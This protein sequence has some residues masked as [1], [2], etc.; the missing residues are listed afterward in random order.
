M[1]LVE[2]ERPRLLGLAYRLVGGRTD[3]ED[4]VQDAWLRWSTAD[5]EAILNPPAWLTTVTTRLALDRIREVERRRETYVGPW[6]PDPIST[7]R[8]PEEHSELAESLTLGFLVVLD[9]LSPVERA[10]LLLADVFAEPFSIIAT[11]VGKSEVACRQIATRARRK[12]RAGAAGR[13]GSEAGTSGTTPATAQLLSELMTAIMTGDEALVIKLVDPDIVLITDGG[14]E[15]HAARRP[16]VGVFRV[17]RFLANVAKRVLPIAARVSTV[18]SVP[19]IVIE[20]ADGGMIMSAEV[21]DGR[22]TRLFVQMNPAKV[23]DLD[24]PIDLY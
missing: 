4:V 2:A 15:R 12:V 1:D 13:G 21:R 19:A 18:N 8:S 11:S 7:E 14:P 23:A 24:R 20:E 5:Q 22:V 6:L 3:A 9:E 10:V 17:H 16:V